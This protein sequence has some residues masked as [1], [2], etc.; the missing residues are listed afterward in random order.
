MVQLQLDQVREVHACG[1]QEGEVG[2][3]PTILPA[4]LQ[5]SPHPQEGLFT[6]TWPF[7]AHSGA[8]SVGPLQELAQM[9]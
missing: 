9:F 8:N 7:L 5:C 1:P 6:G 3:A 2:L 4:S